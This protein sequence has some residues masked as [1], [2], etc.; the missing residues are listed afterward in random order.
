MFDYIYKDNWPEKYNDIAPIE[1][2]SKKGK[3]TKNKFIF[4]KNIDGVDYNFKVLDSSGREQY[5]SVTGKYCSVYALV[6]VCSYTNKFSMTRLPDYIP[7][8]ADWYDNKSK[9]K[10]P[11]FIISTKHDLLDGDDEEPE[12]IE[13]TEEDFLEFCEGITSARGGENVHVYSDISYYEYDK[14]NDMFEEI[15][16]EAAKAYNEVNK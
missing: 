4:P 3:E 1:T 12:E 7:L 15:F 11:L 8:F 16:K 9:G 13:Y 2:D 5:G 14:I 6:L 10:T